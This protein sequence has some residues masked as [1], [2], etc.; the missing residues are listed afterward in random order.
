[1]MYRK[2]PLRFGTMAKGP[3]GKKPGISMGGLDTSPA[4][5]K[6]QRKKRAAEEKRWASKSGPVQVYF[7]DPE[8]PA[9]DD[10]HA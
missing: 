7:R 9:A 1:M 6:R 3:R 5:R 4:R 2:Y 8:A 10:A